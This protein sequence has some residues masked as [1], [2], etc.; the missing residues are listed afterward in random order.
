[1]HSIKLIQQH[2][3]RS[4]PDKALACFG[5]LCQE[6]KEILMDFAQGYP[7]SEQM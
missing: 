7:N 2:F 3:K 4:T 5:A 1:L 6:T